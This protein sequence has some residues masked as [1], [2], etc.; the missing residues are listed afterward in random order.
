L[1]A[2][3]ATEVDK[4][5]LAPTTAPAAAAAGVT[6]GSVPVEEVR[7]APA[8]SRRGIWIA[9]GLVLAAIIGGSMVYATCNVL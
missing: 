2:P 4:A 6:A 3:A 7:E 5:A 1:P 9:V 8:R